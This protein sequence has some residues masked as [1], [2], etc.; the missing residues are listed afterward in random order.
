MHEEIEKIFGISDCSFSK[1]SYRTDDKTKERYKVFEFM[2]D[3]ELPD[4]CPKC[5]GKVYKHGKR[6]IHLTDVPA[7]IPV[8]WDV[9]VPRVRC[10]ECKNIWMPTIKGIDE[11]RSLT[12]RAFTA[13]AQRSLRDAFKYIGEDYLLSGNTVKNIFVDFLNFHERMLQFK[14]PAFIGIDEIKVKRLGELTVI[15]D[16]EHRTLFDMLQGRNQKT[17]TEYF[18]NLKDRDKV[19]WV[20]SDMYRPFQKTIGDAMPNATWAIDHFHVVMKANEAVDYVRRQIQGDMSKKDR[21]KTKRGLAYTLKTRAN[22]LQPDEASAIKA[23]RDD[24]KLHPLAVAFDLKEDFFNIY[25]DNRESRDNAEAAFA[26][27]EKSIPEDEIYAKFRDLAATVHNFY[28]QIFNAWDC[29]IAISNGFTECTNRLIRENNTR[30]RGYSFDV[31]RGRTLYRKT[32]LQR[33]LD[34][35]LALI[36][37]EIPADGPVFYF[38]GTEEDDESDDVDFDPDT[39]EIFE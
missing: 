6:T 30:G 27:W 12:S 24:D 2:Y 3:G 18:M 38:E 4:R 23:C 11:Q 39:G 29:P 33:V 5:G 35:N 10:R 14:T 13:I 32:N 34:G 25:D 9:T 20:C 1:T 7:E 8:K 22:E 28:E 21:I 16:L 19:L 36:G 31:L 17:L 15:T 37:P 26:E